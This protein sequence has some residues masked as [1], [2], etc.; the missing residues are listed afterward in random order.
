MDLNIDV[1]LP[2]A[3]GLQ[4][5]F[6]SFAKHGDPNVERQSPTVEFPVFGTNKN[7]VD[8]TLLG[9]SKTTDSELPSDRCAFWQPAPYM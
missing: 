6:I 7:I 1:P 3:K 5:Y 8:L 2:Y 4:S 9:F